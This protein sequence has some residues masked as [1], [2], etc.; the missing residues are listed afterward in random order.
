MNVVLKKTFSSVTLD[1]YMK[2]RI[3]MNKLIEDIVSSADFGLL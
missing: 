1:L 3:Y 2:K